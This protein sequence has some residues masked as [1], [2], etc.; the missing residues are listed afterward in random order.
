MQVHLNSYFQVTDTFDTAPE[1]TKSLF[2]VGI[3]TGDNVN[4]IVTTFSVS[5]ELQFEVPSAT[6]QINCLSTPYRYNKCGHDNGSS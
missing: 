2:A 3:N 6:L 1:F 5:I 4:D